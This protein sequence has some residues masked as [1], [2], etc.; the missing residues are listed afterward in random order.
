MR[1][2][3]LSGGDFKRGEPPRAETLHV[4][5]FVLPPAFENELRIG[6]EG[7]GNEAAGGNLGGERREVLAGDKVGER[8]RG[9][10]ESY[11]NM[12]LRHHPG[13]LQELRRT[14]SSPI[15]RGPCPI[16]VVFRRGCNGFRG[17]PSAC[18]YLPLPR[19]GR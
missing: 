8:G 1:P 15:M 10:H 6:A 12:T 2:D 18:A 5:G 3:L 19:T 7:G 4:F 16:R 11:T 14:F 17:T 9:I 13:T